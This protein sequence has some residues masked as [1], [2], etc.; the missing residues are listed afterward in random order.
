M[1]FEELETTH[2]FAQAAGILHFEYANA[3]KAATGE[4]FVTAETGK[5]PAPPPAPGPGRG[6]KAERNALPGKGFYGNRAEYLAGRIKAKVAKGD[7]KAT[8][9]AEAVQ[10]GE[11][12]GKGMRAPAT[13]PGLGRFGLDACSL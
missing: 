8:A 9:V 5:D 7:A 3:R 10:R 2:R 1:T 12:D 4:T 13:V 6:H 11:Y